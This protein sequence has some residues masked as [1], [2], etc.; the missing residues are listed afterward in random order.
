MAK[1]IVTSRYM[2][3]SP[4]R[5]ATN[6]VKYMGTREGVEK[7]AEGIEN[8]PATV[9]QQRL[10][11]DIIKFDSAAKG[12]G[13]YQDFEI[14]PTKSNA[15]EFIDAFIERNAER[16]GELDKLVSYMAKR[17][18]VEKLGPHGLFSQTDDKIDLD[19]VSEEVGQHRGIIWTHVIS[20]HRE[21]AERLGYNRAEAWREL[22]R[23][24]VTELAEAQ[25]IDISNL[26]WYGAFHNTA[27]HP[28]M[29]L[30][31]YSRDAK[32]GWLTKKGIDSLRSALGND[33]FRLEQYKLF[34]M[35]TDLR[36]RLKKESREEIEKLLTKIR[37]SCAPTSEVEMLFLKLASQLKTCKGRK[38]YGYLPKDVKD[39]VNKIVAELAKDEGIARLNSEW[40]KVNREKLSLYFEK[41]GLDI[42]LEDN[43]E[44]RSIKNVIV[45]S[46]ALA[47]RI[48]EAE[49]T[50]SYDVGSAM[51]SVVNA[52]CKIISNSY[53]KK[54]SRLNTQIDS[55][56]RSE[57][58]Q[59]KA[60]YGLKTE[61]GVQPDIDDESYSMR[62]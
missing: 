21:D 15:T 41:K 14:S 18:G 42:S 13:E 46:A 56:L 55:K 29:H 60:A 49:P 39:T 3:N 30:L 45:R 32:Q 19:S 7:V 28:H 11:Q 12:Y 5:S 31:V 48:M 22:V 43:P 54:L 37:D 35:E 20:L 62:M 2:R 34:S 38:Q 53:E 52:M 9:R 58:E 36:D 44:F 25:K 8:S 51:R 40:N 26:E 50:H 1:I 24:N 47:M 16:I 6:L 27:H 61:R 4:K 33:I 17:P 23:R 10:V 59:K 57:I